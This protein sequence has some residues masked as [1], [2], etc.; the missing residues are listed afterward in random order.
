M[1]TTSQVEKAWTTSISVKKNFQMTSMMTAMSI[2]QLER[3]SNSATE[4]SGEQLATRRARV[5]AKSTSTK[6]AVI[7][8]LVTATNVAAA[9]ARSTFTNGGA[10][11]VTTFAVQAATKQCASRPM[12]SA[13]KVSLKVT[14]RMMATQSAHNTQS[15]VATKRRVYPT[16]VVKGGFQDSW[17]MDRRH[18][19]VA[20]R[21]ARMDNATRRANAVQDA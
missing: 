18:A 11:R 7:R 14:A 12:E 2:C 13:N 4:T 6:L 5:H 16:D 3:A 9:K 15:E 1:T 21:I 8:L 10:R 17:I 19:S 20:L